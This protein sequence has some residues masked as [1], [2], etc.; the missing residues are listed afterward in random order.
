MQRGGASEQ[1]EGYAD[2]FRR[3]V[4]GSDIE[5]R[6]VEESL[7]MTRI[8]A[9]KVLFFRTLFLPTFSLLFPYLSFL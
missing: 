5:L 2:M 6:V 7:E 3:Q 4:Y 1:I 8:Q 9:K